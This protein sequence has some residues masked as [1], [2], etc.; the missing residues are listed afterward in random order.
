[1]SR[2]DEE[3][4]SS[5]ELGTPFADQ[6]V[7]QRDMKVPVWG[8]ADSGVKATVSFAGGEDEYTKTI[9]QQILETVFVN[10]DDVRMIPLSQH[11]CLAGEAAGEC[12]IAAEFG[13]EDFQGD[14]AI[15]IRLTDLIDKT[16]AALADEFQDFEL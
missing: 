2:G 7:L 9:D 10:G 13:R 5:V 4:K 1:M 16:H 12:R 3:I 11:T 14:G 6:A 8:W 15:Q